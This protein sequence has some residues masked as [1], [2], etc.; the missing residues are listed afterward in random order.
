[1]VDWRQLNAVPL[2]FSRGDVA[3]QLS[4]NEGT[5]LYVGPTAPQ[6]IGYGSNNKKF[7]GGGTQFYIRYEDLVATSSVALN[8]WSNSNQFILT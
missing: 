8:K 7:T 4:I 2:K 1:M 3:L 5:R 6:Q